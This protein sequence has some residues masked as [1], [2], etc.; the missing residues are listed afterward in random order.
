MDRGKTKCFFFNFS[1]TEHF[2]IKFS[3]SRITF[4][5]QSILSQFNSKFVDIYTMVTVNLIHLPVHCREMFSDIVSNRLPMCF[6][7]QHHV[8][9][10]MEPI[11]EKFI[12]FYRKL[13]SLKSFVVSNCISS[14]TIAEIS[15]M[16]TS[17]RDNTFLLFHT[18]YRRLNL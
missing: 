1:L 8:Q 6:P 18:M 14:V 13:I 5:V 9:R 15:S 12:L 7:S 4:S 2:G 16:H 10:L 3:N 11:F 17:V